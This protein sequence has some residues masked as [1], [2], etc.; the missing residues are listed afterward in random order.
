VNLSSASDRVMRLHPAVAVVCPGCG[1]RIGKPCVATVPAFGVGA[2]G[3]P[4]EGVHVER[5]AAARE[6][7]VA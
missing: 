1:A 4:I 6:A 2:T 3:V 7:G 5:I